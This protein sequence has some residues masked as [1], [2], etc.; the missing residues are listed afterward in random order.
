MVPRKTTSATMLIV[1]YRLLTG[2]SLCYGMILSGKAGNEDQQAQVHY[3]LQYA[4]MATRSNFPQ[5]YIHDD[6][7]CGFPA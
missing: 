7:Y 5:R 1:A 4:F 3:N 6:C 2:S